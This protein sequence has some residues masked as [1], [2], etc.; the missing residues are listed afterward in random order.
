M[1]SDPYSLIREFWGD[2]LDAP[3]LKRIVDAPAEHLDAFED[4]IL[5]HQTG[6][7]HLPDLQPGRIRPVFTPGV[8]DMA[9]GATPLETAR[10]ASG[11]L[12]YSHE[13]VM[14][15]LL[16]YL[17]S[18]E[19]RERHA[20]GGLLLH[21]K[22]L[23]EGGSVHFRPVGSAKRHP[24]YQALYGPEALGTSILLERDDWQTLEAMVER[25]VARGYERQRARSDVRW[26]LMS[27]ACIHLHHRRTWGER[28]HRLF[29]SG[30]EIRTFEQIVT[31]SQ[32]PDGQAKV[33]TNLASLS[34]PSLSGH[35][36]A[37]ITVRAHS[38]AFN[39]WRAR[40]SVGLGELNLVDAQDEDALR[41]AR[42]RLR[43]EL[44]PVSQRLEVETKRSAA[45]SS[46]RAGVRGF[47]VSVVSGLAGLLAGGNLPSAVTAA[48]VAKT[49]DSGLAYRA[50]RKTQAISSAQAEL[51]ARI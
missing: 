42:S 2:D 15:D 50:E 30:P 6:I 4:L 24:A 26:A 48:A 8:L 31:T 28:S 25:L 20:A 3:L 34:V 40:L 33:L 27:D 44:L 17:A 23:H 43:E 39:D 29:R 32:R 41:E 11:L 18:P 13:L 49:V 35:A 19:A 21:L 22:A 38:E 51:V 36:K 47:G 16:P 10:V 7:K 14:D 12:L 1:A 37:L 5:D 46:M 45:L 9:R